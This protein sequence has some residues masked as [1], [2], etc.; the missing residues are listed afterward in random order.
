MIQHC[1]VG[2]SDI[3]CP[4]NDELFGFDGMGKTVC[5]YCEGEMVVKEFV[6]V[7]DDE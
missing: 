2:D 4:A 7:I 1:Y 5:P 6:Q 3:Y